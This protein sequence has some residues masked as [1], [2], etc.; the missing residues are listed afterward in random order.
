MVKTNKLVKKLV[1][2]YIYIYI[3]FLTRMTIRFLIGEKNRFFT[4]TRCRTTRA[5]GDN[6]RTI[7]AQ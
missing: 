6:L 5:A 1:C 3:L 4:R 7:I 2:V